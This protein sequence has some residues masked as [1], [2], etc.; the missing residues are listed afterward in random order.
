MSGKETLSLVWGVALTLLA[1][2]IAVVTRAATEQPAGS[3]EQ[4]EA[5]PLPKQPRDGFPESVTAQQ[6]SVQIDEERTRRRRRGRRYG[7]GVRCGHVLRL[8]P[9]AFA[10]DAIESGPG[11]PAPIGI[12]TLWQL[13]GSAAEDCNHLPCLGNLLSFDTTTGPKDTQFP[14]FTGWREPRVR[15]QIGERPMNILGISAYYHDSAACL[16]QDGR[17]V[18]AAQEERFTRKK[19]DHEFPQNA[20][21]F[22]LS[23]GGIA[24]EELDLVTFYDKPLLKFDRI[25]ETYIAYSPRVESATAASGIPASALC[26]GSI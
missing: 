20:V 23:E 7:G 5:R 2:S 25:L 22:C 16:V 1:S 21:D 19:H 10:S 26:G 9:R 24:G 18:A 12:I 11:N 8:T 3:M 17:I 13:F 15:E 4:Q 6:R 14:P